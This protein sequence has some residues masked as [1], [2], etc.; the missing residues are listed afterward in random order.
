M[1]TPLFALLV[2]GALAL[3]LSIVV[4]VFAEDPPTEGKPPAEDPFG[5]KPPGE[6]PAEAPEK[7]EDEKPRVGLGVGDRAVDFVGKE[8][9]NTEPVSLKELRGRLV[10]LELFSTT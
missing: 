5:G 4:P 2:S 10:L 1:R 8:F 7:K 3:C 9:I 6:E